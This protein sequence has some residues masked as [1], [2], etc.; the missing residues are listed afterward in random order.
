[1]RQS[2]PLRTQICIHMYIYIYTYRSIECYINTHLYTMENGK[3][4]SGNPFHAPRAGHRGLKDELEVDV[5][6]VDGLA[7]I[8]FEL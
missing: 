5:L 8:K 2:S 3:C 7:T 1:M 4:R 6:A